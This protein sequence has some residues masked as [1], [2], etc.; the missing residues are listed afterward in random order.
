MLLEL[1]GVVLLGLLPLLP[2]PFLLAWAAVATAKLRTTT[3]ILVR[4]QFPSAAEQRL[5]FFA[6]HFHVLSKLPV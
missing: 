6:P 5:V 2:P 3:A 1:V 4:K